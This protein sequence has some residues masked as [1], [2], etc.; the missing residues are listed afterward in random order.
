MPETIEQL[1]A[2]FKAKYPEYE[3]MS[4]L[5]VGQRVSAR[6]DLLEELGDP[7]EEEAESAQEAPHTNMVRRFNSGLVKS[8]KQG[9][10]NSIK[11]T[12]RQIRRIPGVGDHVAEMPP[13]PEEM[14]KTKGFVEGAGKFVGDVA[15]YF[16]PLGRAGAAFAKLGVAAVPAREAAKAMVIGTAQ[17]GDAKEGAKAAALAGGVA[18]T[19][20]GLSKFAHWKL[21]GPAKKKIERVFAPTTGEAKAAVR[22]KLVP[23]MLER[24]VVATSREG[25][26][27]KAH[28]SAQKLTQKLEEAEALVGH[29]KV[30]IG[31]MLEKLDELESE[32]F[33]KGAKDASG[34]PVI[35]EQ[36]RPAANAIRK[37]KATLNS[38]H[39]DA[40]LSKNGKILTQMIPRE[41][42]RHVRQQLDEVVDAFGG[43]SVFPQHNMQKAATVKS[44]NTLRDMLNQD[45]PDIAKIN[46]ELSFWLNARDTMR[47]TN[48]RLAGQ[49]TRTPFSL[50][51]T[52]AGTGG[53]VAGAVG[54]GNPFVN[55][56]IGIITPRLWTST[57]F[58]TVN[59]S[60]RAQLADAIA[61]KNSER[62]TLAASRI[63]A[64]IKAS[65]QKN[66]GGK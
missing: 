38:I 47:E 13:I 35:L 12:N 7:P 22:K 43:H 44:V 19:L 25:L 8:G 34:N 37:L 1:G 31:R 66:E 62:V 55:M 46:K 9:L 11:F 60:L 3:D 10:W 63:A 36:F 45:Q 15:P 65:E 52:S 23:G 51:E 33:I 21:L 30:N 16:I 57:A 4:D 42:M 5:D 64:A 53:F 18:G 26:E 61:S 28:E 58:R 32:Q 6:P 20:Q 54:T 50:L 17:S 40:V 14:V 24:R 27:Q 48:T 59:A 2:R 29:E 49:G 56:A 39:S 41:T